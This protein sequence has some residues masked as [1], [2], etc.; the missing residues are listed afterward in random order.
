VDQP[1]Y[2]E[3]NA[4]VFGVSVD[5]VDSHQNFCAQEGLNFRLLSDGDYKVSA[6]YRSLANWGVVKFAKRNTFLIDPQ[7]KIAKDYRS[8][9]PA[10]HSAEVLAE[11]DVLRGVKVSPP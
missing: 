3:R 2:A 7:G 10:H 6:A 4:V 5:G 8:V 9:N 1:K 11:L